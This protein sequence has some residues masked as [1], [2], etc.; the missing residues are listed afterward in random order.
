MV[1]LSV[2]SYIGVFFAKIVLADI[3]L[4]RLIRYDKISLDKWPSFNFS[5]AQDSGD[6]MG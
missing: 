5:P 3:V 1:F 4:A 2:C 6:V